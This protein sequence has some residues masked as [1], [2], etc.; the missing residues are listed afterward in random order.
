MKQPGI[1]AENVSR[2]NL[3]FVLRVRQATKASNVPLK[4]SDKATLREAARLF[5]PYK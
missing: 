1:P 3:V 5:R 4:V 2:G